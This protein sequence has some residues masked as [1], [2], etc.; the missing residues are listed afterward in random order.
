MFK[1]WKVFPTSIL[2]EKST[3]LIIHIIQ[4][5]LNNYITHISCNHSVATTLDH[6]LRIKIMIS[7]LK[8]IIYKITH[9]YRAL[10]VSWFVFKPATIIF[11]LAL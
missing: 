4:R 6:I 11:I 1:K 5:K 7:V 8:T 2:S 9:K 3:L 10:Q